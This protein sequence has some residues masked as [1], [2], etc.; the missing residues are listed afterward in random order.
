M[1]FGARQNKGEQSQIPVFGH[2]PVEAEHGVEEHEEQPETEEGGWGHVDLGRV[3][4]ALNRGEDDD[5]KGGGIFQG[6]GEVLAAPAGMIGSIATHPY[7]FDKT[8]AETNQV[9]DCD[10]ERNK[11]GAAAVSVGSAG[12]GGA[13][14]EE[15]A[16]A[17]EEVAEN[18]GIGSENI[19]EQDVAE[20]ALTGLCKSS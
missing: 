19:C 13:A 11:I 16:S 12:A 9:G 3:V 20:F 6:V 2:I 17:H 15:H 18:F 10:D 5:R 14:V 1:T 4:A 8:L 7:V